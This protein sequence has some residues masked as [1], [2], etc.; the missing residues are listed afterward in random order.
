LLFVLAVILTLR[1]CDF[2][3][4]AQIVVLKANSLRAKKSPT[5]KKVTNSERS[6]MGKDSDALNQPPLSDPFQPGSQPPLFFQP[7]PKPATSTPARGTLP[8]ARASNLHSSGLTGGRP[9]NP[10]KYCLFPVM[11]M[12][13]HAPAGVSPA[14]NPEEGR[15]DAK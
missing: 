3:V 6:R 12:F 10:T 13:N 8:N 11:W 9:L 15:Y 4:F 7:K 5:F 14:S 1:G 2:F